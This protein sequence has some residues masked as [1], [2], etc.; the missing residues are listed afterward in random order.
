[1]TEEKPKIGRPKGALPPLTSTDRTRESLRKLKASGGMMVA[2]R[3]EGDIAQ[4]VDDECKRLNQT[5]TTF[6]TGL[7]RDYFAQKDYH[8]ALDRSES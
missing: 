6:I 2:L 1:M 5:R 8:M 4:R 7:I 3:I